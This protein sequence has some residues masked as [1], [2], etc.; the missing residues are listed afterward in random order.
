M[1]G[2]S[3][4][5]RRGSAPFIRALASRGAPPSPP[6]TSSSCWGPF[7]LHPCSSSSAPQH[8]TCG[9]I[10]K[11]FNLFLALIICN[12]IVDPLIYAFRSQELR[13]ETLQEVQCS[14]VRVA[15]PSC[16]Q[17]WKSGAVP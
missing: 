5:S 16:A 4:G 10:F 8:P 7:F 15:V 1:P 6:W 9:C 14:L 13:R 17:A 2:A 3:P 12:A 11:N